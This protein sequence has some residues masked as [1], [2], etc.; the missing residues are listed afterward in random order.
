MMKLRSLVVASTLAML[1]FAA[2]YA[3]SYEIELLQPLKAGKTN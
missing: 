3:K 2:A 1:C